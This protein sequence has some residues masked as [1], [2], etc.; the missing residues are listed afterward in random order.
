[1]TAELIDLGHKYLNQIANS[2]F[3]TIHLY[4]ALYSTVTTE[5]INLGYKY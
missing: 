5:L 3:S 1:M 4:G 2:V